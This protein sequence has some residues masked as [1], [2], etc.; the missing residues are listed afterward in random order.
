MC[1]R[2][3]GAGKRIQIASPRRAGLVAGSRPAHAARRLRGLLD[4][5]SMPSWSGGQQ[6]PWQQSGGSQNSGGGGYDIG[7]PAD[8]SN[9]GN[10]WQ[11]QG[12]E[13][14]GGWQGQGAQGQQ[15]DS[16]RQD[17]GSSDSY[18]PSQ[19]SGGGSA[20]SKMSGAC[21]V[22]T[23]VVNKGREGQGMQAQPRICAHTSTAAAGACACLRRRGSAAA[24]QLVPRRPPR[25]IADMG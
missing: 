19:G 4:G 23:W 8:R 2:G 14:R 24:P 21:V 22:G 13:A 7:A 1:V 20:A 6:M 5:F 11:K 15:Q 18:S 10:N 9:S 3:S 12:D 16:W 17:D 25:P